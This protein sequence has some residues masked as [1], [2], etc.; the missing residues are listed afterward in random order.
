MLAMGVA[1]VRELSKTLTQLSVLLDPKTSPQALPTLFLLLFFLLLSKVLR[2]FHFITDR[3]QFRIDIADNII[4][5]PQSHRDG[6][7]SCPD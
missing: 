3:R 5:I 2:L 6:F 7:S 4:H 1:A